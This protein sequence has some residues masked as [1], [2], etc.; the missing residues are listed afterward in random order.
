M[1]DGWRGRAPT[2]FKANALIEHSPTVSKLHLVHQWMHD[3]VDAVN[4]SPI[5]LR[6]LAPSTAA[7]AF[8]PFGCNPRRLFVEASLAQAAFVGNVGV[9]AEHTPD[10]RLL[11]SRELL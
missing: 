3:I 10:D 4:G 11:L 5:A 1:R 8:Q 9:A 2:E 7:Y 6:E